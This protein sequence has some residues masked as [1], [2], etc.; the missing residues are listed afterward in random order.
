M[1]S[2]GIPGTESELTANWL[3]RALSDGGDSDSPEIQNAVVEEIGS[4]VGLVGKILRCHLSYRDVDSAGPQTVIVKLPS[5]H[6]ETAQTARTLGLYYREYAYYRQVAHHV[7][8]RSPALL[9]GDFDD[10]SHRFVLVLEDLRE[11]AS[12]D[13]LDGASPEQAKTAIR[14]VARLHGRYWNKVDEPPI[15]GF[16]D[17]TSP[18][19]R[20]L[21]R[22]VYQASLPAAL[23]RFGHLFPDPMRWLAEEYGRSIVEHLEAVAAGSRTFSHGDFR[24][25]NMFFSADSDDFAVVDW[26]VCGISSGLYDVAYFLSSSVAPGVRREIER[27]VLSEYH[28]VLRSTGVEDFT[29][30]ECWRSYR[31]VMLGCF[32]TPIVAGGQLDFSSD[33]S[34]QLAE[35][36]LT[37]T[38]TAIDDL[39][40][41]EFLPGR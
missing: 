35:V 8:V 18:E 39:D 33:R 37:R 27:E 2:L 15:S 29:F 6:P 7:P 9:Y 19:R 17:S 10:S 21:V 22:A 1:A 41:H 38:L 36:F 11:M 40:A 30:E 26:Q 25:D 3:A 32:L 34:R 14:A 24:L 5:S 20:P 4:G 23:N 31:Q 16:H 13:Q 12:V 28:Q